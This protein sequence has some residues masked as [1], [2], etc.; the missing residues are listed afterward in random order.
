MGLSEF[1]AG[2]REMAARDRKFRASV[3]EEAREARQ[4]AFR[5][6]SIKRGAQSGVKSASRQSTGQAFVGFLASRTQVK[7]APVRRAAPKR[8]KRRKTTRRRLRR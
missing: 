3:A 7:K 8:R 6:E 1:F 5:Q 2:K 4:K